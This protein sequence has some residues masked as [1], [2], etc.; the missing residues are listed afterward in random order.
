LFRYLLLLRMFNIKKASLNVTRKEARSLA[1][2]D[3]MENQIDLAPA[4]A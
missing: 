1:S 2:I 3:H 4:S